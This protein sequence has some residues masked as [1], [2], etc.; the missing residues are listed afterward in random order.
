MA[1]RKKLS[2]ILRG[3]DRER[4]EKAWQS[5]K[6]APD[7]GPLPRGEYVAL[8]VAGE[9]FTA[10]TGTAGFKFSFEV[11]EGEYAGR[12]FWMDVWLTETAVP[13]AKR[14]VAW[15]GIAT[16][17]QLD[18]P[19]PQG[20]RCRVKLGIRKDDDGTERNRL[21]KGEVIA[22]EPP[23]PDAFAPPDDAGEQPTA[24]AASE[25]GEANGQPKGELFPFGANA[26]SDGP[27]KE[28]R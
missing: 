4:L 9:P 17:S 2:D 13:Q 26:A 18:N 1:E 16:L 8:L 10:K 23:Q 5:T 28:A 7:F 21:L 27:Y 24:A 3:S 11:I 22:I 15:L 19:I 25:N 6:A 14:D 20:L 12:R